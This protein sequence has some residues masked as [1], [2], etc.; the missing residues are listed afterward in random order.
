[1][2]EL[3]T[4]EDIEARAKTLGLPIK[5]ICDR[6]GVALSTFYRWKAGT[7]NPSLAVYQRLRDAT[8]GE[9]NA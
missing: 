6:A 3:L 9:T 7:L 2:S 1:M 5:V 8:A 4:P